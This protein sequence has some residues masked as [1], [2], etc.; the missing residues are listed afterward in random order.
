MRI[1][2]HFSSGHLISQLALTASPTGEGFLF[3]LRLDGTSRRDD[4]FARSLFVLINIICA[5][6]KLRFFPFFL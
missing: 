3:D 1:E 4:M 5:N 2:F 6:K